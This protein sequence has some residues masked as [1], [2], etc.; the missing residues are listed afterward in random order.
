MLWTMIDLLKTPELLLAFIL[1]LIIPL[2]FSIAFHELAHGFVAYKFGD[3]TPKIMG[4]L[5]LNPFAHLD[6]LGTILLLVVGLGWAKPVIININNIPNQTKQMLVA[7]AGPASNFL[8]ALIFGIIISVLENDFSFASNHFVILLFHMVV[9]INIGLALFNLL[10]IPPMDGSRIIS[11][12]LPEKLKTT[13]EKLE[14]YGMFIL[15]LLL[16]TI[17]FGFIFKMASFL[18]SHLYTLLKVI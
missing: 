17:G 2:L 8:L 6:V 18:Q 11:W 13:Y 10:P 12:L 4:R 3:M 7:L 16:V 15:M 9:K 1:L 14:A 5:T